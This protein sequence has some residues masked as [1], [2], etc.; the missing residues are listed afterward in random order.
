VLALQVDSSME[1]FGIV[2]IY[3]FVY[4]AF[5]IVCALVANSRGRSP[6]GWFFIGV[7]GNCIALIILLVIPD[8]KVE[9]EKERRLR[10]ENRRLREL[11]KNDRQVSDARHEDLNQRVDVHDRALGLDTK[12]QIGG[13]ANPELGE[14]PV[15]FASQCEEADWY[16][17]KGEEQVGPMDFGAFKQRWRVGEFGASTLVWASFMQDWEALAQVQGLEDTLR[18]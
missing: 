12:P 2:A 14:G 16:F 15:S 5:G 7:I 17:L 9:A 13:A 18:A 10:Q 3:F 4:F 11:L 6:V 8:L 1:V